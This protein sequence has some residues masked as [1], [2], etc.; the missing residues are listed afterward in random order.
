MD[1]GASFTKMTSAMCWKIN[2]RVVGEKVC[3][4]EIRRS[5]FSDAVLIEDCRW[6]N[7]I[8]IEKLD[9]VIHLFAIEVLLLRRHD[10]IS[11][12]PASGAD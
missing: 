10:F 12:K 3:R 1:N 8:L 4:N 6:T 11:N 5:I 2:I 7:A 9:I